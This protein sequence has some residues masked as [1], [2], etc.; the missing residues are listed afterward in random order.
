MDLVLSIVLECVKMTEN[1]CPICYESIT[2]TTGCCI[3]SCSHSFHIK[4]LTQWTSDASTCPMCRH[5]L[6]EIEMVPKPPER[7]IDFIIDEQSI[8]R[9]SNSEVAEYMRNYLANRGSFT[10]HPPRP[11]QGRTS[12][13]Q[14][15][16]NTRG[17]PQQN[18]RWFSIAPYTFTTEE[19]ITQVIQE[20]GVT[21]NRA[22][23]ELRE[24]AG[25]VDEAILMARVP[26]RRYVPST[27][28]IPRN[29]LEPTDEMITAW[30]LERLFKY[31][32]II[33]DSYDYGSFED[34]MH[35]TNVTRFS[36]R[37]SSLWMNSDF[38]GAEVR[39]RSPSI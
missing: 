37:A 21:R 30:A 14:D 17:N 9:P 31:G 5:S 33:D 10:I 27:P 16:L 22:I 38:I 8:E 4:C 32:T 11:G 12:M 26:R 7:D 34:T 2:Q 20:A 29:P 28:P 6:T 3:L 18:P 15:L 13:F 39:D 24:S 25:N 23:Q 36:G 19:R 35:R 1:D